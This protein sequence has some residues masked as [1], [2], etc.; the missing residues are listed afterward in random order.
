MN[1]LWLFG[2]RHGSPWKCYVSD[3]K[4]EVTSGSMMY[5]IYF[6]QEFALIAGVNSLTTKSVAGINSSYAFG[7]TN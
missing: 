2:V 7:L 4:I 1:L 6:T 3:S 5:S